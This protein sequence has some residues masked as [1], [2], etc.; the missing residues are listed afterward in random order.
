[1]RNRTILAVVMVFL[2]IAAVTGTGSFTSASVDRPVSIAVV[3]DE[4]AYVGIHENRP[5]ISPG[6]HDVVLVRIANRFDSDVENV[7]VTVRDDRRLLET[8]RGTPPIVHDVDA[9]YAIPEGGDGFVEA[10]VTCGATN[11]EAIVPLRITLGTGNVTAEMT[12]NVTIE[13]VGPPPANESEGTNSTG[14]D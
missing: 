7:D 10:N 2:S 12:R 14:S 9:P 11:T 13:C 3:E 1:M 8:G 6:T 5:V 4:R